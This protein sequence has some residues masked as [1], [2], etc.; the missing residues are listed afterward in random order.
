[1]PREGRQ[2]IG[3]PQPPL[4]WNCRLSTAAEKIAA[5]ASGLSAINCWRLLD[6]AARF[7]ADAPRIAA[8]VAMALGAIRAQRI[9]AQSMSDRN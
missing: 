1:M 8:A 5:G 3:Q 9:S 2:R 6:Y 7:R 4:A